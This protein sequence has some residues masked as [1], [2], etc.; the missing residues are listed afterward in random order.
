MTDNAD[1]PLN[2]K[3]M[4]TYNTSSPIKNK[5]DEKI[6]EIK[7]QIDKTKTIMMENVERVIE[8]GENLDSLQTKSEK[9]QEDALDFRNK[10]KSLKEKMC[11]REYKIKFMILLLILVVIGV[12]IGIIYATK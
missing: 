1:Q 10:S 12:L 6:I 5:G 8:R 3:N 4:N 9:L 11:M 7:S 2:Q